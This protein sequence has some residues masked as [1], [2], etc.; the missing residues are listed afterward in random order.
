VTVSL[1]QVNTSSNQGEGGGERYP[2]LQAYAAEETSFP[3]LQN[4]LILLS[5]GDSTAT[6]TVALLGVC[7]LGDMPGFHRIGNLHIHRRPEGAASPTMWP[8]R[9]A[10]PAPVPAAPRERAAVRLRVAAGYS[11]IFQVIAGD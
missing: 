10:P 9:D 4:V 8:R 3:T 7:R 1:D 6:C 11:Q 5:D 2:S